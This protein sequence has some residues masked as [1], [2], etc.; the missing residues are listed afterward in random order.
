M[1]S[2]IIELECSP[3]SLLKLAETGG[4]HPAVFAPIVDRLKGTIK[5]SW[6]AFG[7][8]NLAAVAEVPGGLS[9]A[10]VSY[11]VASEGIARRAKITPITVWKEAAETL[12]GIGRTAQQAVKEEID[13]A[14][15]AMKE[16]AEKAA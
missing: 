14:Q 3:D 8:F 1:P 10:A 9:L 6:L 2:Y 5:D 15:Q 13:T 4:E 11:A 16:E 7:D 12:R